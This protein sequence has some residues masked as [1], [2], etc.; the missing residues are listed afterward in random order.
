MQIKGAN[1][2]G[3]SLHITPFYEKF[4]TVCS[5]INW[6]KGYTGQLCRKLSRSFIFTQFVWAY[7][8]KTLFTQNSK[9]F[10]HNKLVE[11]LYRPAV[12]QIKP[13]FCFIVSFF[14]TQAILLFYAFSVL[15]KLVWLMKY[16]VRLKVML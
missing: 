4:Q 7:E 9:H 6:F 14:F 11:E 16:K 3:G 5:I 12:P 8:N 15:S 13:E 10:F 2:A 1:P